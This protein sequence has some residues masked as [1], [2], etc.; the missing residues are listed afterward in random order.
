MKQF[1]VFSLLLTLFVSCT[2]Q[3]VSKTIGILNDTMNQDKPLTSSEVNAGLK[4]A[5]TQGISRGVV[6]ASRTDGYLGNPKLR[7]PF[8]E[9]AKKVE[10][11]LRDIGLGK[12]VDKFITSLNRG[13]EEAAKSAKPIFVNAVKGMSINDVFGILKGEQNAATVYLRENTEAQ[14]VAAFSTVVED[15]LRKVNATKY[16]GELVDRY[17]KIPMVQKL[18]P[19]LNSY[20][21]QKAIDG[22]FVLVAEEEAR[23]RENPVA[24]TTELLKRVFGSRD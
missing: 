2:S 18:D 10:N 8:P 4:E 15:A 23:I 19:D 14:L 9:D 21:T 3:Q 22:L 16:Y 5:L 17:N 20:A 7:I 1:L 12:E 11:T 24:R 6:Q 13:A